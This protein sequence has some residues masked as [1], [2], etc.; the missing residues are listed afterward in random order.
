MFMHVNMLICHLND[1]LPILGMHSDMSILLPVVINIALLIF[2][3]I[4]FCVPYNS[5]VPLL[6]EKLDLLLQDGIGATLQ[7]LESVEALHH[8]DDK[9]DGEVGAAQVRS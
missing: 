6:G 3:A 8:Q 5:V 2:C 7:F 1:F 9:E 4:V